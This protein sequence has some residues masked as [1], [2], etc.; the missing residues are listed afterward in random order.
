[1]AQNHNCV[2]TD[3]SE[4]ISGF[5]TSLMRLSLPG[6]LGQS[7]KNIDQATDEV[8]ICSDA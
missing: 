3:L 7:L 6:G 2:S 8:R 4:S 5:V 1:M